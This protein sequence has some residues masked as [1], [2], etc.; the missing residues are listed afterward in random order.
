MNDGVSV[1]DSRQPKK[2]IWHLLKGGVDGFFHELEDEK[3]KRARH[4]TNN[5]RVPVGRLKSQG[6]GI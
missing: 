5:N 6:A 3:K 4:L 1:G 2:G